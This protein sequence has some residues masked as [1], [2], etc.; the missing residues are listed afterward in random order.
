M[1]PRWSSVHA[2][3]PLLSPPSAFLPSLPPP[4]NVGS[5]LRLHF[6]CLGSL[7]SSPANKSSANLHPESLSPCTD[8]SSPPLPGNLTAGGGA[9]SAPARREEGRELPNGHPCAEIT[10]LALRACSRELALFHP[11]FLPR[12]PTELHCEVG[13]ERY[14]RAERGREKPSPGRRWA[15]SPPAPDPI[16]QRL[17]QAQIPEIKKKEPERTRLSHRS[18]FSQHT[19]SP[20][21]KHTVRL[22]AK[23]E[24]AAALTV[25]RPARGVSGSVTSLKEKQRG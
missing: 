12:K 9:E 15:S 2:P 18:V 25:I 23:G 8:R 1:S 17:K 22:R 6:S 10:G 21:R 24:T 13:E 16:V 20:Q 3:L 5:S 4:L 11:A 7:L 19:L 14:K